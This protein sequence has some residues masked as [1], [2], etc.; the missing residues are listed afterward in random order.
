MRPVDLH[1]LHLVVTWAEASRAAEHHSVNED[2]VHARLPL[3]AV[4]DGMGGHRA[5]AMASSLA[6]AALSELPSDAPTPQEV[7][8]RID[9]ANRAVLDRAAADPE[10]SGM[11]TTLA[12][13][14]LARDGEREV[15]VAFN[16][17]DSRIYRLVGGCLS[18][19]TTDHSLVQELVD[20]GRLEPAEAARDRRRNV[21]TRALGATSPAEVDFWVLTPTQG[22]RFL[23]CSDGFTA[24]VS[25][26]SIARALSSDASAREI[27][28]R[29]MRIASRSPLRD[30]TSLV[31]VDV[32]R[33][34]APHRAT[35]AHPLDSTIERT[36]HV[37]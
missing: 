34:P 24:A 6:I 26:E 8:A 3:F 16:I 22:E 10:L 9:A 12:G 13:L 30:D 29:L 32:T 15:W 4:A 7:A 25:D 33:T 14:A 28:D 20:S 36:S 27:A 17:G 2:G 23:I 37:S 11:G 19:I 35:T 18:Q 21:V 5:G 1:P 31:V